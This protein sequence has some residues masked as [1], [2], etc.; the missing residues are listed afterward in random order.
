M[1]DLVVH[2]PFKTQ[3]KPLYSLYS[4]LRTLIITL[5]VGKNFRCAAPHPF[6]VVILHIM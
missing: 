2:Y 4:L 6:L 1:L 3:S 5:V